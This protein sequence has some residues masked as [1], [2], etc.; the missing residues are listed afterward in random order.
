MALTHNL[1]FPRVGKKRELK[2]AVERYWSGDL[3]QDDLIAEGKRIRAENWA[4]Q[5]D[6]GVDLLPVGDFAWYDHVLN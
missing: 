4:L 2:F 1:G 5:A 3:T 6:A